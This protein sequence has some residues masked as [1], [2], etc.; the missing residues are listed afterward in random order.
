MNVSFSFSEPVQFRPPP[1]NPTIR[2]ID[3]F[4]R[5]KPV[6][7]STRANGDTAASAKR[8][9]KSRPPTDIILMHL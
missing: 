9:A 6:S 7:R 1:V 3:A 4:P 8:P 5:P 2:V